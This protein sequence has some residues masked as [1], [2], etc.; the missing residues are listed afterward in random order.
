MFDETKTKLEEKKSW[1]TSVT[2]KE[3]QAHFVSVVHNPLLLVSDG[4]A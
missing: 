4:H 3:M 2:A 1:A